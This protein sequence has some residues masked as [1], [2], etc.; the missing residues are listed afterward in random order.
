MPESGLPPVRIGDDETDALRRLTEFSLLDALHGRR[1]RRFP[2]GGH[3]PAG[4]LAYKSEHEIQALSDLERAIVLA[5]VAG[6]TG[7][8]TAIS[9]HPRY[10]PALPDYSGGAA[11]RTFPSAA[12]FEIVEFFFTDESGTYF[13]PTRDATPDIPFT[14]GE[15]FSEARLNAVLARAQRLS[16]ERI[17]IPRE[18][19]FLEGHNTWIANHP[20]SLLVIPVADLAQ[21][22]LA[23]L[24]FF[25][26]NGFVIY[27]DVNNRQIPGIEKYADI[28]KVGD[29][30]PLTFLEQYSLTEAT[31]ELMTASY[32]GHLVLGA[33]G[34]GGWSFD[35]I[36]RLTMLGAS[37]R[38]DVP[39]LG[40]RYDEDERWPL[41]NPTGLPGVFEGF[42]RPH[43]DSVGD[44]ID[45]YF[46]RK[47]GPGGPFHPDTP[48]PWTESSAV[49]AAAA[50]P[51]A[52]FTEL[53]KVQATY[54]DDTFGKFPGTVPTMWIMN[55]LQAQHLDT[56]YYDKLFNPG[57][58]L[59]THRDHQ[60]L[61]HRG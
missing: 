42:C 55:Y 41:P 49:R 5:S 20:G 37:G 4:P 40:F 7:W 16:N 54:I 36:D 9:H 12:G 29:P 47:Y 18:E 22:T 59:S 27:D 21:H 3:I 14:E 30:L 61:W 52:R 2:V 24:A 34:L 51:D 45:A 15:G 11:G 23:N 33:L 17:W 57:A 50:R 32:N 6:V 39:G 8:H 1:S 46:E 10:A 25:V 31:A 44:A 28:A 13:L 38:D 43:F 19:P 58:Y 53:M 26:R 48:G 56:D 60:A 35:G